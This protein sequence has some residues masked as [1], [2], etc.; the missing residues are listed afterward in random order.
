[1]WDWLPEKWFNRALAGEPLN[2]LTVG[3]TA[4]IV[5]MLFH[6]I[7]TAFNAMSGGKS[8]GQAPGAIPQPEAQLGQPASLWPGRDPSEVWTDDKEAKYV[9]DGWLG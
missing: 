2:W 7:M 6:V 1:M 5:L 9:G 8:T 3:V 4:T